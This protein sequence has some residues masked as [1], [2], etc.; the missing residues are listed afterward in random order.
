MAG[1]NL[2]WYYF[3]ARYYDPEIC[4]WRSMDPLTHKYPSHSPYNYVLNNPIIAIDEQG[5]DV[6]IVVSGEVNRVVTNY[7]WA[8]Q[9]DQGR[10][11]GSSTHFATYKMDVYDYGDE[12]YIGSGEPMPASEW[13]SEHSE[14][15]VARN[16]W[17]N[18]FNHSGDDQFGSY[19]ET[20]GGFYEA[21]DRSQESA[22]TAGKKGGWLGVNDP[23][24]TYGVLKTENGVTRTGISI[25]PGNSNYATGCL[26]MS[27]SQF[28]QLRDIVLKAM[29]NGQKVYIQIN[30][31]QATYNEERRRWEYVK[32]EEE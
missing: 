31:R 6:L 2:D 14:F 26:T 19:N 9:W 24:Q 27:R 29:K 7:N 15:E 11:K 25:H 1:G 3:G 16:A 8:S 5:E 17:H 23:G 4:V 20:P 13:T 18:E 10:D 21:T 28:S 32:D 22:S 30:N 12:S